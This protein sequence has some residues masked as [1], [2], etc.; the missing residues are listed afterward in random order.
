MCQAAC[1]ARSSPVI[2]R[3]KQCSPRL[4][5]P[6]SVLQ[7][8]GKPGGG[9]GGWERG[10]RSSCPHKVRDSWPLI[11]RDPG[12][13]CPI[14]GWSLLEGEQ[15][16][17]LRKRL[18][19]FHVCTI[20]SQVFVFSKNSYDGHT[21]TVSPSSS[22]LHPSYSQVVLFITKKMNPKKNRVLSKMNKFPNP[23]RP[24]KR[25]LLIQIC[26]FS[27]VISLSESPK[28]EPCMSICNVKLQSCRNIFDYYSEGATF[29]IAK[30]Y[31]R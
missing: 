3:D 21:H 4:S 22:S 17:R 12:V 14:V 10:T 23:T 9:G 26:K 11:S 7:G 19:F 31:R 1:I 13:A 18:H 2:L 25:L 30:P 5:P 16:K 6:R 28:S 15:Q 24:Y 8:R 20:L 27:L 29:I